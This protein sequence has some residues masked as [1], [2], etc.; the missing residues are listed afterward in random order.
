MKISIIVPAFNAQQ[1]LPELLESIFIQTYKNFEL[2]VVDDGSTDTTATIAHSAPCKLIRLQE[3]HGPAYCRN[4]G[5]RNAAGDLIAFTDSDCRLS[6][7]WL[8]NMKRHFGSNDFQALM[9]KLIL[10]PSSTLGNSISALGFPAGGSVGFDKIWKVDAKGFTNSLS[11]CNCAVKKETFD[12]IGGFD[13]SFPYPGGEDS[14]LAYRLNQ[15]GYK[16]KYCKDVIA[17][18]PARNSLQGFFKWH[19][20][21]GISSYIFSKK[22]DRKKD[23]LLLRIRST[24]NII[25]HNC[26]DYKFPLIFLL[27]CSSY[28]TQLVGVLSVRFNKEQHASFDH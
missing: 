19:F 23:F 3:N 10:L 20:R 13:E 27:L 8:A 25:R 11:T 1:T 5:V 14:L 22:V 21:R 2:I 12:R 15:F 4:L 24:V 28:L 6:P 17:Y 9:G 7:D 16:I 18:H 26:L